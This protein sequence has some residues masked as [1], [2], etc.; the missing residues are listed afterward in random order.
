MIR[1]PKTILFTNAG[2]LLDLDTPNINSDPAYY[3]GVIITRPVKFANIL[4]LKNLKEM[5]PHVC[6]DVDLYN[7][8]GTQ[9]RKLDVDI[10][11][12]NALN[13]RFNG[14][15]QWTRISTLY[16]IPG[17]YFTFKFTFKHLKATETFA[18]VSCI[19]NTLLD[20]RLRSEGEVT[21]FASYNEYDLVSVSHNNE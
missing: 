18:G 2:K 15:Q 8:N 6:M 21:D 12:N 14:V 10:Y 3:D 16:W 4:K 17:K 20:N 9:K 7:D 11:V 1:Y 5:E 13:P 19:C